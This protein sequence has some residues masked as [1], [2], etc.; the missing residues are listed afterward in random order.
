[1]KDHLPIDLPREA[2]SATAQSSNLADNRACV[3]TED[4]ME[5]NRRIT[6]ERIRCLT[7][8]MLKLNQEIVLLQLCSA[9]QQLEQR[10]FQFVA[11][12][13]RFLLA[14]LELRHVRH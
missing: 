11:G 6:W 5:M 12:L 1:M 10:I 2:F 9:P 3:P 7:A 13:V 14:G 4:G 8:L